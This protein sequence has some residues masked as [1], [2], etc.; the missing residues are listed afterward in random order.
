[1]KIPA[2]QEYLIVHQ[3]RKRVKLYGKIEDGSWICS[4]YSSG[5]EIQLESLPNG[6]FVISLDTIYRNVLSSEDSHQVRE[7][8]EE[9]F[10]S[11]EEAESL[12]W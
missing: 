9:Y 2:L 1:M 11:R 8:A 12:D 7:E 5:D 6:K 3:R 10:L 4:E